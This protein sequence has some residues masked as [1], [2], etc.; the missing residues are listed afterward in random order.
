MNYST[1]RKKF[2]SEKQYDAHSMNELLDYVKKLYV[3]EEVNILE[4]RQ[5]IKILEKEGA[6]SPEQAV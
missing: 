4:Y 1:L 2:K 5:I 3:R 6:K